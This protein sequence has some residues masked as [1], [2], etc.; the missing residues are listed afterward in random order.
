VKPI[1]CS[2]LGLLLLAG[3]AV[4][5]A[6]K[7]LSPVQVA[8]V[9]LMSTEPYRFNGV[10]MTDVARGSG[11]VAWNKRT[12]FSAAHVVYDAEATAGSNW[13]LPP[14]WYPVPYADA[15]DESTA[16][17]SRGYYRFKAYSAI[18]DVG[19]QTGNAFGKDVILGFA[20]KDLIT[21]APATLNLNGY[22]DLGTAGTTMI[23][24][25]PAINFYTGLPITGYYL[26]QTGPGSTPYQVSFGRALRSTLVTTGSGNSG[27]P[28]W[29]Q[30][31]AGWTA[32]GVLVGGRPSESIV[33]SFSPDINALTRSVAPVVKT[34]EGSPISVAGVGATSFFF[35]MVKAAKAIPDGVQHWTNFATSVSRFDQAAVVTKAHISLNITTN[36]QGD[37]EVILQGPGGLYQVLH[38]EEGGATH[39][40]II[41]DLDVTGTFAGIY[42]DG[43]WTLRVQDRLK[44]DIAT[45]N[46]AVLEVG[47]DGAVP[48]P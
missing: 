46:S 48:P 9:G 34:P 14:V 45:I 43:G 20:F 44:G 28:I 2:V 47:V 8:N 35:P 5:V 11:F 10:V 19:G 12:F 15:L 21:G 31:G 29:T 1:T 17:P 23:T 6:P 26:D 27:G 42:A 41:D 39:N 16:I 4:A 40:L 30:K 38:N 7:T 36:H 18:V 24:G 25:Y 3:T 37:L 13:G 22:K 32:A 33:Y